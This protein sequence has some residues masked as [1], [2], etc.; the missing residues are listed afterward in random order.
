MFSF[1]L[2]QQEPLELKFPNISYPALDLLKV[3]S[4]LPT[5]LGAQGS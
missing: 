5:D 4:W 3:K 1:S 2:F